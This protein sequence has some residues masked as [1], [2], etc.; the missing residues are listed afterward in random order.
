[1][2]PLVVYVVW[3]GYISFMEKGKTAVYSIS[4]LWSGIGMGGGGIPFNALTIFF[5]G[6]P[7]PFTFYLLGTKNK[8]D[9]ELDLQSLIPGFARYR[10][11]FSASFQRKRAC[12][13]E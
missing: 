10:S 2:S 13:S 7:S 8:E 12:L 3:F 1:M 6:T 4:S 5:L 11:F 9:T